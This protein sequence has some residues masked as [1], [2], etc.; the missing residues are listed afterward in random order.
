MTAVHGTSVDITT[1]DGVADAYLVHP[2]DGAAHPGVIVYQDAFGLRPALRAVADRIASHGYTVLVPN[3]FYRA[4]R[5]PLFDLPDPID[6]KARPDIFAEIRPLMVQLTPEVVKS[7]SAAYLD[8]LAASELVSDGPVGLTGYCM[9]GR[10]VLFTAAAYPERV[11]AGGCFHTSGLV[12]DGPESTHLLVDPITA[13]LFLGYADNDQGATP[14]HV[15]TFDKAL[16]A[17]GVTHTTAVYEGA[18]HGYTQAD[19]EA[20]NEE[21][22]ERHYRDLLALFDRTLGSK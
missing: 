19:T 18:I 21:A 17:A 11:A 4:G 12:T 3:A 15:E 6:F 20:Y 5:A 8:W 2:D 10:L 9:G 7:D 1:P 13:E 22:A 16:E 14:E